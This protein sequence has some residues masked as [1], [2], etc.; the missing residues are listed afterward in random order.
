MVV[1]L[2]PLPFASLPVSLEELS[3]LP[4]D[5][6]GSGHDPMGPCVYGIW[7]EVEL[8]SKRWQ[9]WLLLTKVLLQASLQSESPWKT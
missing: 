3:F 5:C 1:N 6:R 8:L 4:K 2:Q 7:V 9:E